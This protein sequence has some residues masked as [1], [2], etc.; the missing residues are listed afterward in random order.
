MDR[1]QVLVGL[2]RFTLDFGHCIRKI[3]FARM[4]QIMAQIFI[5]EKVI[6][7]NK[8]LSKLLKLFCNNIYRWI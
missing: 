8:Y 6:K 1:D 7:L 5:Y 4:H 2:D 3:F